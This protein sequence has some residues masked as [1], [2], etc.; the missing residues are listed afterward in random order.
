MS[1]V[2][3]SRRCLLASL[4]FLSLSGYLLAGLAPGVGCPND[5]PFIV[6]MKKDGVQLYDTPKQVSHI[7][8]AE[9]ETYGTCCDESVLVQYA[10]QDYDRT[11]VTHNKLIVEFKKLISANRKLV[12][13]IRQISKIQVKRGN[14]KVLKLI[15]KAKALKHSQPFKMLQTLFGNTTKADIAE[16]SEKNLKCWTRLTKERS[17][18]ICATCSGR[19]NHFFHKN[20]ILISQ[21][22]C[23]E[24]ADACAAPM[25]VITQ[26]VVGVSHLQKI[27]KSIA[28]AGIQ[29]SSGGRTLLVNHIKRIVAT[30]AKIIIK[31]AT[32][33]L[34]GSHDAQ[35]W[36][37]F[38]QPDSNGADAQ[39]SISDFDRKIRL[40]GKF[41]KMREPIMLQDMQKILNQMNQLHFEPAPFLQ[42]Y[43]NNQTGTGSRV[44]E[45]KPSSGS[46]CKRKP[47]TSHTAAKYQS[48]KTQSPQQW[49][50]GNRVLQFATTDNIGSDAEI[51]IPT[52]SSY[53]SVGVS[54]HGPMADDMLFP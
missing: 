7:C 15:E 19:S 39:E 1:R 40:C 22:K 9:F 26:L 2:G 54:G 46:G 38:L 20:K 42:A 35:T 21:H 25:K 49:K 52:D 41:V 17:A 33:P 44:P 31:I 14:R 13:A 51:V 23:I 8:K 3:P 32:T 27:S 45:R 28:E 47:K 12:L 37:N 24:L 5:N 4:A 30:A 16:F 29:I 36:A 6:I 10:N 11:V 43:I 48:V 53:S 50:V 34:G 18:S